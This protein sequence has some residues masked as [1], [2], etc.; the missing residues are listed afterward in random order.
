MSVTRS[1]IRRL[2]LARITGETTPEGRWVAR[3]RCTPSDRPRIAMPTRPSTKSPNSSF[4]V[5]NSSMI[6]TV[7]GIGSIGCPV[8]ET[9]SGRSML[10]Q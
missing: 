2:V 3:M 1:A 5:A 10:S 4:R 9:K 6:S 8:G 7:R